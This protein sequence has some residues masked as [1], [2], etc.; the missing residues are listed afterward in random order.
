MGMVTIVNDVVTDMDAARLVVGSS[1]PS[2][3]KEGEEQATQV[4]KFLNIKLSRVTGILASDANRVAR[5]VTQI[6]TQSNDRLLL[7]RP[8]KYLHHL[9]ERNM[10]LV[11][12][13]PYNFDSD[14]FAHSRVLAEKGESVSQCR[15]R[16]IS[17]LEREVSET[18]RLIVV[19]HPLA[20]QIIAN[21][22]LNQ[23]HTILTSFWFAKGSC[24]TFDTKM[25]KSG[26]LR[27]ELQDA[28]NAI[29]GCSYSQD[30]VYNDLLGSEG[31]RA[32]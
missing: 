29:V 32:S 9:R 19:S 8:V 14:L 30:E 18:D 5:L 24:M 15:E 21:V 22:Y 6:R 11:T 26:S 20:C 31:H 2:P 1:N 7:G 4:A 25:T 3:N 12:G 28:F 10:G 17:C 27:W 16:L 13:T 23:I